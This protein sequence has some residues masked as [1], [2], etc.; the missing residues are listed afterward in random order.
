MR[1]CC[2]LGQDSHR[3]LPEESNKECVLGGVVFTDVPGLDADSDGDVIF[4]AICNAI[5]SITHVPILGGIAQKLC[6]EGKITNSRVYLEHALN[7]LEGTT[8]HH[9]A[10]SLEGLRPKMQTRIDLVRKSIAETM[11]LSIE[12]IGLT[13]TSG[14]HLTRFSQGEGIQCFCIISAATEN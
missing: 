10:L 9:V 1:Y 2:G 4:H 7:T 5:T 3:F 14:N 6:H 11:N 8:I 13:I 12:Q